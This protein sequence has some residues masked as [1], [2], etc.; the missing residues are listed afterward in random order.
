MADAAGAASA[1][2]WLLDKPL[3]LLDEV[4]ALEG[5]NGEHLLFHPGR[6]SY[7]RV[8]P[9][10]VKLTRLLDGRRTGDEIARALSRETGPNPAVVRFLSELRE[11]H[12]LN[13]PAPAEAWRRRVARRSAAEHLLRIPLTRRPDAALAPLAR[14]LGRLPRRTLLALALALL[15]ALGLAVAAVLGISAWPIHGAFWPAIVA[16]L[17]VQLLCHE[18]AHALV[19]QL[20]G[21]PSREAGIGLLFYFWPIPYVDRTDS[22]RL[23]GRA[24]R[25]AIVLAGPA[26]DLL[27]AGTWGVVALL[28]DGPV[29]ATAEVLVALDLI[30]VAATLNPFLPTDG[31]QAI[32][33]G[34]GELNIR[35]RAFSYL[36][37]RLTRTP[38]PSH[39]SRTSRRRAVAYVAFSLACVTYVV[40]LV[41]TVLLGLARLVGL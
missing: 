5:A 39:L 17:L 38:L 15:A 32:E 21:V 27:W 28:A 4:E 6:G 7:T 19:A 20:Y 36:A 33:A 23:R 11:A 25:A 18:T 31:Y 10:G 22:Y 2:G 29:R 37:H 13:V 41:V 14:A 12:L 3:R 1:D 35:G 34:L 8:T 40:A 24:A 26:N 16:V 30:V 9:A